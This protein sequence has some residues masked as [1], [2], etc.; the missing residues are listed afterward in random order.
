MHVFNVVSHHKHLKHRWS[1]KE[2]GAVN[3]GT[4]EV[5]PNA[6]LSPNGRETRMLHFGTACT[7][8]R[9]KAF[10]VCVFHL[11]TIAVNAITKIMTSEF[12]AVAKF[13]RRGR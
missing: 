11:L 4:I 10:F 1:W 12:S 2:D 8:I 6:L 9:Q 5:A 3:T 7:S 13:C